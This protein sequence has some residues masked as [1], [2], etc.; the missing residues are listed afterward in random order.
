MHYELCI[1]HYELNPS[2]MKPC[3]ATIGTFDGVHR[4]HQYVLQ[5]VVSQARQR[6]L[7]S[8]VLTFPN[9]PMQVLQ[10]GFQPQML[11]L[12]QEKERH[13]LLTGIDRVEMMPF[14]PT[15]AQ[16]NASDFM[17]D[18]LKE[19]LHV[20]VLMM[21]YDNHFGHGSQGFADY[22]RHGEKLGME[23]VGCEE[24][25]SEQRI[26]STAIRQ[27]LLRGAVEDA[28]HLLGYHYELEGEVVQGFQNGRKFGYPTANLHV[29]PCKLIP[30]NGAYLVATD[31]GY[32]MLNV[33]TRP[34]LHNG[35]QRSIEVHI[36]DY[37][38]DL[39]GQTLTVKLL[40]HLRP[41]Q[42]FDTLEALHRQ[43]MADEAQCRQLIST[44]PSPQL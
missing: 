1:M 34:T 26:S 33:G 13:L 9:H 35:Q 6:G 3:V 2:M 20:Q 12:P 21:G 39:Y 5:Q 32:G 15:L 44:S 14:T 7:E 23:V 43:L 4:G 24:L 19:Q 31:Q 8:V 10:D 30:E 22:L 25:V 18:I 16:M 28:H 41:E 42:E 27:A 36:F 11:T 17:R 38:G 29:A 40:R 37:E